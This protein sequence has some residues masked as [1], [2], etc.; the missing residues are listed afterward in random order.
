MFK[1]NKNKCLRCG[2]CI[3]VCP[4]DALELTEHGIVRDE[5]KCIN[6]GICELFCPVGAIKVKKNENK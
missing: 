4:N 3:S 6:C 5:K 1:W 2:G